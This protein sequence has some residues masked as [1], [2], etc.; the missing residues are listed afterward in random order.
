MLIIRK[1]FVSSLVTLFLI[2]FFVA[3][4]HAATINAASVSYAHVSAAVYSA[5]SGDTVLVPA[6]TA[7]WDTPLQL[8]RGITLQGS[9]IGNTVII[10][11]ISNQNGGI[12]SVVPTSPS[13]NEPFR[14]TGFTL[15]GN[16]M[17][18]GIY[19]E[20]RT[21]NV[22]NKIRIDHNRILRAG[23]TNA[24]RSIVLFGTLYGVID[25]NI[26][27]LGTGTAVGSYG[28]NSDSWA[29]L[30][31]NFGDENNVYY[32]DNIIIGSGTYFDCGHGGRYVA[33][34]NSFTGAMRNLTPMMDMHGNQPAGYGTMV[35]EVYGNEIDLSGKYGGQILDQRGGQVL[36]FYNNAA[37]AGQTVDAVKV[38]E[39]YDD[40]RYPLANSYLMH[41]TNSYYWNNRKSNSSLVTAYCSQDTYDGS[42]PNSLP[43]ILEN[44][45][46]YQQNVSFNGTAGVGCGPLSSR[47]ATCT[48]GVS[49]WATNQSCSNTTGMAGKN[50]ATPISGTLYK[51][52]AT[53]TWTAYYSPY[54]YPHPLRSGSTASS[55]TT[56]TEALTQTTP[57]TI[58]VT[59]TTLTTSVARGKSR[60]TRKIFSR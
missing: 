24:G 32:E 48:T 35:G 31:R 6:G 44:R 20:N 34:Y 42:A 60:I 3:S 22:M 4:S 33:R 11:N 37:N 5:S 28:I 46:F 47:P 36:V 43:V 51:C 45:E 10:S 14:I 40:S 39:E 29:K 57:T 16:N 2:H 54:A 12:I 18:N 27:E 23:G 25:S 7:I 41:V 58:T 9:G 30:T 56:A 53:N 26:I 15:D 19:L 50:P 8:T 52:T 1:F 13:F 55:T 21:V 49:Y 59:D 38:R 17:S